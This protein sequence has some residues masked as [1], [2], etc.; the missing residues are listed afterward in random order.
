MNAFRRLRLPRLPRWVPGRRRRAWILGTAVVLVVA[1]VGGVLAAARPSNTPRP[2]RAGKTVAAPRPRPSAVPTNSPW[3]TAHLTALTVHTAADFT[4]TIQA[5]TA[6]PLD[7]PRANNRYGRQ[8]AKIAW[9]TVQTPMDWLAVH[10]TDS[11]G[12]KFDGAWTPEQL[13]AAFGP[14]PRGLNERREADKLKAAADGP[15]R[16]RTARDLQQATDLGRDLLESTTRNHLH[17]DLP[18]PQ[19]TE[20]T[21]CGHQD[22]STWI[23]VFAALVQVTED[24]QAESLL[25]DLADYWSRQG[26]HVDLSALNAGLPRLTAYMEGGTTAT[27]TV[28]ER[29]KNLLRLEADTPCL[30]QPQPA[31]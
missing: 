19:V 5:A 26:L 17:R 7:E 18:D 15:F 30:H 3:E 27:A 14:R 9:R 2:A 4:V 22:G 29:H 24:A 8:I 11:A 25:P 10:V 23:S 21:V 6:A 12:R 1:L 28:D 16:N 13:Q 20:P 31:P